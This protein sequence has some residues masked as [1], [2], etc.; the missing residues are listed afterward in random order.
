MCTIYNMNQISKII[1]EKG[2]LW[3][4][5]CHWNKTHN[6]HPSVLL[7]S[8]I[9]ICGAFISCIS[10]GF[11]PYNP[12]PISSVI[13]DEYKYTIISCMAPRH[14]CSATAKWLSQ[15]KMPNLYGNFENEIETFNSQNVLAHFPQFIFYDNDLDLWSKV[16]KKMCTLK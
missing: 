12:E 16:I 1:T 6:P 3:F 14:Q 10:F 15:T 4:F 9:P 7:I 8:H 2:W 5:F 13:E 11:D